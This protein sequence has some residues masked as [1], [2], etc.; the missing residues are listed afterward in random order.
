MKV[1]VAG[2]VL[3]YNFTSERLMLLEG[4][5]RGLGIRVKNIKKEDF[6]KPLGAMVGFMNTE[7][8][9]EGP[10]G[11]KMTEEELMNFEDEFMLLYNLNGTNL[12]QF[13]K[14]MRM[15]GISVPLKA[16]LTATNMEWYP[17][18]L[19]GELKKEHEQMQRMNNK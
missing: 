1:K 9:P 3:C 17:A 7:H 2:S 6:D 18:E 14:A 15:A 5:C 11:H 19:C 16:V 13:L 12:D 4:V 10:D 8:S